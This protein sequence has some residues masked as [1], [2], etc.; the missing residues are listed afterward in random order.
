MGILRV[1]QYLHCQGDMLMNQQKVTDV[2]HTYAAYNHHVLRQT[3]AYTRSISDDAYWQLTAPCLEQQVAAILRG[4]IT[5]VHAVW[6]LTET[7]QRCLLDVLPVQ[8]DEVTALLTRHALKMHTILTETGAYVQPVSESEFLASIHD[9]IFR[10]PKPGKL[11]SI[12]TEQD[13]TLDDRHMQLQNHL[14]ESRTLVEALIMQPGDWLLRLEDKLPFCFWD[15]EFGYRYLLEQFEQALPR[16]GLAFHWEYEQARHLLTCTVGSS[17]WTVEGI[18]NIE[19]HLGDPDP[20]GQIAIELFDHLDRSLH[21]HGW[22]LAYGLSDDQ[23]TTA[24][25]APLYARERLHL[26]F[27]ED[28]SDPKCKLAYLPCGAWEF[29]RELSR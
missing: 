24:I 6:N 9:T 19:D 5:L 1:A 26:F 16:V 21:D 3:D 17:T 15:F 7:L 27:P 11:R 2:L 20:D 12:A 8:H 13:T 10:E 22:Y 28:V 14:V 23:C 18:V 29:D 25:V 4:D